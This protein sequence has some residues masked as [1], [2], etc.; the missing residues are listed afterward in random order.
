MKVHAMHQHIGLKCIWLLQIFLKR[1]RP[2]CLSAQLQ[3]A[4]A[5]WSL[6][7]VQTGSLL[8]DSLPPW[9][10]S[11]SHQ[12]F[13]ASL[14]VIAGPSCAGGVP[15]AQQ[16]KARNPPYSLGLIRAMSSSALRPV[17]L[18]YRPQ[19]NLLKQQNAVIY[20]L[21]LPHFPATP[22]GAAGAQAQVL[23]PKQLLAS[24]CACRWIQN[25]SA[26]PQS[27]STMPSCCS[28]PP[29][30]PG[31]WRRGQSRCRATTSW[32]CPGEWWV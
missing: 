28:L 3:M 12:V 19:H 17:A 2:T 24:L 14:R 32:T 29:V 23:M 16:S 7:F 31:C 22:R 6:T 4:K 13:V 30:L 27:S 10:V 1:F 15:I 11:M 25:G 5:S 8:C 26:M 20:G 9:G 21:P 18:Q